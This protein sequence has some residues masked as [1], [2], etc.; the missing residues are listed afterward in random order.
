MPQGR[1]RRTTDEWMLGTNPAGSSL[2]MASASLHLAASHSYA[3]LWPQC[4]CSLHS[5]RVAFEQKSHRNIFP[6]NNCIDAIIV[7][8]LLRR[9]LTNDHLKF[10]KPLRGRKRSV[11]PLENYFIRRK[12][13]EYLSH[14]PHSST[15]LIIMQTQILNLGLIY[16]VNRI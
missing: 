5:Y 4:L 13:S 1:P 2:R 10:L 11:M 3:T 9:W 14:S 12:S 6:R 16:T 15:M 8:L 7:I